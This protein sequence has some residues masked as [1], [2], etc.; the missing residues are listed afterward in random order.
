MQQTLVAAS[1]I[2]AI[3][4]IYEG[5]RG[6][7]KSTTLNELFLYG[8]GL[9]LGPFVGTLAATNFSLGNMIYFSLI[10]GYFFGL[11]ALLWLW[12]GFLLAAA[13][14]VYFFRAGSPIRTYV[15]TQTNSG[16]VHEYLEQQYASSKQ[17]ASARQLRLAASL[18][19]IICLLV[20]LTLELFLAATLLAPL[21]QA[22]LTTT[23]VV[24][25]VIIGAYAAMGGFWAVVIT[26]LLQGLLLTI[27]GVLIL[28]IVGLLDLPL[29]S[30]SANY[31]STAWATL[32]GPGWAGIASIIGIT[33]GWY[34]VTMDTWQRACASRSEKVPKKGIILGQIPIVLGILFF[35]LLGMY[36]NLGLRDNLDPSLASHHSQGYNALTDLFLY[37]DA[38]SGFGQSLMAIVALAFVL[39]GL[40]TADTFLIV[41]GHSF[42][43]DLM[44]GIMRRETFGDLDKS[45]SSLLAGAG[46]A[47]VASLGV[48]VVGLFF[49]LN[50]FGL[51]DNPLILFYLA[52]SVQFSLFAPVLFS[53]TKHRPPSGAALAALLA[54]L[55]VSIGWGFGFSLTG[56]TGLADRLGITLDDL[57]YLTP[58]PTQ[59]VGILILGAA[60]LATRKAAPGGS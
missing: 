23:F 17:D 5:Y 25:A 15:T 34:L 10:W 39:A 20:A 53:V 40:S 35:C 2:L 1:L 41:C 7:K 31:P 26:D 43:S 16:S 38:L 13:V 60:F 54:S 37:T 49:V 45:E 3:I 36:D 30:Y 22:D 59:L 33:F 11:S 28:I 19:T 58:I 29:A 50:Y 56:H 12:I 47:I 4:L 44:V 55:V 8:G 48:F 57:L 42:V 21:I 32:K 24:L 27:A 46:R 14:Y 52:Y 9:N 6:R 51:L 18:T